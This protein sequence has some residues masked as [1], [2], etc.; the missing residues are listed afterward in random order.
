MDI[1]GDRAQ[2]VRTQILSGD[3]RYVPGMV[4]VSFGLYNTLEEVDAL[5]DALACIVRGEYSGKYTQVISNGEFT[6][7]GWKARYED[8]YEP[9]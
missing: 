5:V 6:P 2:Q 3:R 4:R 8:Y 7:T 9:E 1:Q